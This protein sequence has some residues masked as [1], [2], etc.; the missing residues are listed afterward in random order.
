ML[1]TQRM[2]TKHD[3]ALE[4]AI[5][6][7]NMASRFGCIKRPYISGPTNFRPLLLKVLLSWIGWANAN[8]EDGFGTVDGNPKSCTTWDAKKPS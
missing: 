8:G 5:P 7:S 2:D 6:A 4:N 3:G 1:Y